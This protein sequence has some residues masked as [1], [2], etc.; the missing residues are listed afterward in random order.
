MANAQS[1]TYG[2]V[3]EAG[4]AGKHVSVAHRTRLNVVAAILSLFVP[5]LLF[6]LV[7]CLFSFDTHYK[8]PSMCLIG[9]GVALFVVVVFGVLAAAVLMARRA[10]DWSQEPTWYIFLF[11]T[12][13]LAWAL[14]LGVGNY[15]FWHNTQPFFDVQNL[16]SYSGV[17]PS[18][19]RGQQMMDIG[20]A[21]FVEGTHLDLSKAMGFHNLDTYCVAPITS[22][23]SPLASYDFW[24]VGVNC[25]ASDSADF[26]CGEFANPHASAGLRLMRDEQRP[27]FRLAVQQAESVYNIKATHPLFFT[28]MQDTDAE[29]NGYLEEGNRTFLL[30]IFGHFALQLILVM[31]AS[32]AATKLHVY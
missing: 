6:C 17:D 24:A 32:V 20:R 12:S 18:R 2:T 28:W 15:N 8:Q 31:L 14:A 3:G 30:G 26:R 16:N 19:Q 10:G 25:C 29:A 11:A 5:W 4:H 7:Y 21:Q 9:A 27:F 1:A 13:L 22:G 23:N